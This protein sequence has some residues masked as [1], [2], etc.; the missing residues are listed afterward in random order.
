MSITKLAST[1][2]YAKEEVANLHRQLGGTKFNAMTGAKDFIYG[3]DEKGDTVLRFKIGKNH[4]GRNHC[5]ITLNRSSDTYT[6][7][8]MKVATCKKTWDVKASNVACREGVYS[9]QLQATFT[10][11]TGMYTSL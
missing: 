8:V 3:T 2:V 7:Q 11:F 6:V 5:Q 4:T 1:S 10:E 9:D